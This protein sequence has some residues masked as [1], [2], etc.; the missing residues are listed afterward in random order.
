ML[1]DQLILNY[2]VLGVWTASMLY[3]RYGFQR[4]I[5]SVIERNTIALNR[6]H[7]N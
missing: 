2:G 5:L 1:E 6:L 3:E 7:K 4:K